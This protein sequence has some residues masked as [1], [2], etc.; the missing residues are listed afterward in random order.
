MMTGLP[1][2]SIMTFLPLAGA[3]FTFLA[4]PERARG[5]GFAVSLVVFG[6]AA[7][8]AY[9][10]DGTSDAFQLRKKSCGYRLWD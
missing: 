4:R 3:L 5:I 9:M 10:F 7:Y 2:L 6:L 8:V 1:I